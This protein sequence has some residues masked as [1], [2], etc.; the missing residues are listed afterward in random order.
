MWFEKMRSEEESQILAKLSAIAG[1]D[2]MTS[3]KELREHGFAHW[4]AELLGRDVGY[5]EALQ[6]RVLQ[7]LRDEGLITMQRGKYR[8]ITSVRCP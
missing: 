4:V 6:N 2:C 8:I 3:A 1:S 5:E 7:R